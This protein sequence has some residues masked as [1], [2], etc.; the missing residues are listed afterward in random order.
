MKRVIALLRG[1]IE[2]RSDITTHYDHPFIEWYDTGRNIRQYL[3]LGD[4]Q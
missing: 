3:T 1:L 2:A 4:N